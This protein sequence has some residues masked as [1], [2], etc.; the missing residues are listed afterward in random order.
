MNVPVELIV[1]LGG[2]NLAFLSLVAHLLVRIL[3]GQ[4]ATNVEI[5][6]I[7]SQMRYPNPPTLN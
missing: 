5:A 4:G 6:V 7:K 3:A 2:G 1:F